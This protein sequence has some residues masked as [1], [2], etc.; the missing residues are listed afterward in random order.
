MPIPGPETALA[1]TIDGGVEGI[2]VR[3]DDAR[4]VAYNA[5]LR[6]FNDLHEGSTTYLGPPGRSVSVMAFSS[7]FLPNSALI[8]HD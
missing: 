8:E 5:L 4:P 1:S 6:F 7:V 2:I 3:D